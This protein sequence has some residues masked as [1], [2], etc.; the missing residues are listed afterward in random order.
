MCGRFIQRKSVQEYGTLFRARI[1]GPGRPPSW[2]IPPGQAVLAVRK[3]VPEERPELWTPVWGLVPHWARERGAFH[4]INA[5]IET[6]DKKPAYRESFRRRRCLIPSEGYY[7]W[8]KTPGG[9]KQ[10]FFIH[11]PDGQTFALAGLWDSW[12]EAGGSGIETFTIIV[13]PARPDM[14][15]I[16]DRMPVLLSEE[17]WDPWLDPGLTDPPLVMAILTG[18]DTVPLVFD[19]VDRSVNNP[20]NDGEELVRPV[21]P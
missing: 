6:V 8:Q 1:T 20:E 10:P 15:F 9:G 7:E 3:K 12:R 16:H 11:R 21:V 19:P 17:R 2:N 13:R 4:T 18:P 14:R 5:R